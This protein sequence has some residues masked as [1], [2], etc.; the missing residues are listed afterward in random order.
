PGV[1]LAFQTEPEALAAPEPVGEPALTYQVLVPAPD[2]LIVTLNAPEAPTD[3]ALQEPDGPP[4]AAAAPAPATASAWRWPE[5]LAPMLAR[6]VLG[7]AAALALLQIIR[8]GRFRRLLARGAP[9]PL[10]LVEEV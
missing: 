2:D 9:A 3:V 4:P 5:W 8:I 10:A 6:I 7:G 1:T